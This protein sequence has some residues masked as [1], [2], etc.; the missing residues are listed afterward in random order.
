MRVFKYDP[1]R[2]DKQV[3]EFIERQYRERGFSYES[4]KVSFWLVYKVEDGKASVEL[5]KTVD[6]LTVFIS[7]I[8]DRS[9]VRFEIFQESRVIADVRRSVKKQLSFFDEEEL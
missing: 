5:C 4:W 3:Q 9:G 1:L 7:S 2:D 8:Q 6:D